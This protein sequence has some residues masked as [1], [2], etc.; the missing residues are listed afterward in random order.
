MI[1]GHNLSTAAG[2]EWALMLDKAGFSDAFFTPCPNA[3]KGHFGIFALVALCGFS[4]AAGLAQM[5][6][7]KAQL[8]Q[9]SRGCDLKEVGISLFSWLNF[10]WE[11]NKTLVPG[12]PQK[13]QGSWGFIYQPMV[14]WTH[15]IPWPVILDVWYDPTQG[16]AKDRHGGISGET[17]VIWKS[18]LGTKNAGTPRK[19]NIHYSAMLA[20]HRFLDV[21]AS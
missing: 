17:F 21:W 10:N 13:P 19:F 16:V 6:G 2:V 12:V 1:A 8:M 7:G 15:Y 9:K 20:G 11:M 14:K 3:G 5:V 18:C 4:H